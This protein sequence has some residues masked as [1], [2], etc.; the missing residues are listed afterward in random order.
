M[1]GLEYK[2]FRSETMSIIAKHGLRY[3]FDRLDKVWEKHYELHPGSIQTLHEYKQEQ[4][5]TLLSTMLKHYRG[6]S[7]V[8]RTKD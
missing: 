8:Q 4:H 2:I 7:Y 5:T 1:D 3:D 6:V